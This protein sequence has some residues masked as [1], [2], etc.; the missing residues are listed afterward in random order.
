MLRPLETMNT[1]VVGLPAGVV[2][3]SCPGPGCHRDFGVEKISAKLLRLVSF[4][5]ILKLSLLH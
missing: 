3:G 4:E 5:R 2:C 1:T